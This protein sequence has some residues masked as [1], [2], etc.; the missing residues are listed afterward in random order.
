MYHPAALFASMEGQAWQTPAA[1]VVVAL[2]VLALSWRRFSRKNQS[3][4]GCGGEGCSAV[5]RDVKRLKQR[6]GK[7][8]GGRRTEGG[9]RV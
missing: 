5:S 1:L 8:E 4:S 7:K 3:Q 9:G 6:A 2:A